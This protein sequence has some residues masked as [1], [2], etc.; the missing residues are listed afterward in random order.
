MKANI[1][2]YGLY[3]ITAL[4]KL[5]KKEM[6]NLIANDIVLVKELAIKSHSLRELELSPTRSKKIL[7]E[8]GQLIRTKL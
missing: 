5:T 8:V 7:S 4:T 3:P 2:A 1:D 6:E